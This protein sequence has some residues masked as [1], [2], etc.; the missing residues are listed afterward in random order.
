MTKVIGYSLL[1]AGGAMLGYCDIFPTDWRY[2]A[3]IVPL[4]FGGSLT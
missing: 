4:I 2:W 1:F 3:I